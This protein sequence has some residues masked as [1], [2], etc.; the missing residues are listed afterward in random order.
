LIIVTDHVS[1]VTMIKFAGSPQP[2][3]TRKFFADSP[4][5]QAAQIGGES[6]RSCISSARSALSITA[7]AILAQRF[8]IVAARSQLHSECA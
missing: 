6:V 5:W 4:W 7:P 1:F 2:T 8:Q 3:V